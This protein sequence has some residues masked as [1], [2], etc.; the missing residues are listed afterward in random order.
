MGEVGAVIHLATTGTDA[1]LVVRL[2]DEHPDGRSLVVA[3]AIQRGSARA[4]DPE[5]GAGLVAAL[6]PGSIQEFRLDLWAT[7]HVF[8]PGH[9][10][11]VD[12]TSSSAPRWEVGTNRFPPAESAP[13]AATLTVHV[14]DD[15]PSRLILTVAPPLS[16][17][18]TAA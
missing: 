13:S 4:V 17:I 5:T 11:R 16:A 15:H 10:I 12:I 3:D 7:A 2:C 1:D 14:G 6:E 18:E 9:R 8:L